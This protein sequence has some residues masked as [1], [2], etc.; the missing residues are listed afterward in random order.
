MTAADGD[1][2]M[3]QL[4]SPGSQVE[5]VDQDLLT[6]A[7]GQVETAPGSAPAAGANAVFAPREEP[8]APR[9]WG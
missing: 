8:K 5:R 9:A 1:G 6:Q 7:A 2:A 4:A 3:S